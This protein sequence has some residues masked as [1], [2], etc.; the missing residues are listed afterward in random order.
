M[1]VLEP[2][3][4][5]D[6]LNDR[7][8]TEGEPVLYSVASDASNEGNRK[9]FPVCVRYFSVSDGVSCKLLDFL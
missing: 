5:Q 1:N 2:K 8:P 7:S 3:A 6:I 9:M 4:V